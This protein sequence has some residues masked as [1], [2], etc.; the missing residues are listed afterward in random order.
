L[1]IRL[2]ALVCLTGS[3]AFAQ[4]GG[5]YLGPA[6]LSTGA[7][8]VGTR[9]GE[10]VDLRFYAGV[11]GVYDSSQQPVALDSKGNLLTIGGLAGVEVSV[12][13][14]GT[15]SWKTALLGVDYK[16]SAREYNAG[17]AYDSIDQSLTLGY[18]VQESKRLRFDARLTGGIYNNSLA[19]V[20]ITP[21]ITSDNAVQPSTLLFDS[22]SYFVQGSL[23]GTYSFSPRTTFTVG[24]QGFD[25]WRQ[26]SQL[27]GVEGYS[28]TG[29]VEHK[30]S[31]FTSIGFT[32]GRQ[33][34]DFPR[35][36]G[37]SD[38]DT[39]QLFIGT[40]FGRFWNL[41]VKGGV[42]HSEVK[43]LQS[44]T[45]SPVIAALLGTST[46]IQS[47]Y[48]ED[49][50][51]SGSVVLTRKFK[52]SNVSLSVDESVSP[53]NGV[54]LTSKIQNAGAYYTYAGIRRVSLQLSGGYSGLSS[55]GQGIQP[56]RSAFGG[57]GMTYT[58]PYSLHLTA[59][60]DY[61]YQSIENLSYKHT[62]FRT[63]VGLTFSP[64]TVPL[65]IW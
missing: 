37:S 52:Q 2:I 60:Y 58:L 33:H 1:K 38:V 56:Y 55:I 10:L 64:G 45:L 6:V 9:G 47:F 8:G 14:Y 20:G 48:K 57:G 5:G 21:A 29:S 43:G 42:F 41:V 46:T 11:S 31:K 13:L 50:F 19:S 26:S 24:G 18:T 23:Y 65:S 17:S 40:N 3:A 30:V 59:R 35:S 34:F 22:R 36:F 7:T 25:V 54:Y 15:H 49:V 44:V 61:R 39:G 27:V 62:G 63:V 32:Y 16:G 53:G 4:L 28:L 12:G 51:P